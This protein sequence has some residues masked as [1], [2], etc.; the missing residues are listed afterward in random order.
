MQLDCQVPVRVSWRCHQWVAFGNFETFAQKSGPTWL[1][2]FVCLPSYSSYL[3]WQFILHLRSATI[4]STQEEEKD[5]AQ[6]QNDCRQA[7]SLQT[8][9]RLKSTA[10]LGFF[11]KIWV[12]SMAFSGITWQL[13]RLFGVWRN[14][15]CNEYCFPERIFQRLPDDWWTN[16]LLFY[17]CNGPNR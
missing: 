5:G 8:P 10:V 1:N 4:P 12:C 13:F 14:Q 9:T 16:I 2:W 6:A 3:K 15:W 7:L 17:K 11:A